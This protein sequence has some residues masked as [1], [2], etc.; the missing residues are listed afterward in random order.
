MNLKKMCYCQSGNS[1]ETCCGPFLSG[2]KRP[3]TPEALMRS[4]FSAFCT[5]NVQY[6]IST[7]YPSKRE[8]DESK[9]LAETMAGTTWLGLAVIHAPEPAAGDDIGFVEFAAFYQAAG[10]VGQLH[11]SSRFMIENGQ[12]YYLDG[13]M[14]GPVPMGRNAPCFCNSG[15]KYKKCHG[16]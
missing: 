12:W 11:E 16:K 9:K 6:L 15:K 1:F 3:R 8:P 4:R 2:N 14:L 13:K 10:E 5:R 7:R